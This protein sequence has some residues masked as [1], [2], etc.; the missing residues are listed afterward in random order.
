M[1]L[2]PAFT[3]WFAQ[4]GWTIRAHQAAMIAA[5]QADEHAL[6]VAATGAGK[7]LAG[8]LP[9][10]LDLARGANDGLHTLYVSPLK[11]LAA[12]IE[13]NLAAPIA[14]MGLPIRVETRSG[15]TSSD[16]KAR[17]RSRPPHILLTTPES[18]SLLLSWPDSFLLFANLKTVVIDE[19]HAF[20]TGKRGD[21]LSLA[22]ARLQTINPKL[23][24]VAL[25]ATIADPGDYCRWLAPGGDGTK[26]R[27]VAGEAGAEPD[28]R[29]LMPEGAIPWAGHSG[30]YAVHQVMAE[31]AKHRTT[32]IFCNTRGLAELL[33]QELWKANDA[34]LPIAIH[35]GSLDREARLRA[36][37]A[38]AE[39]RLRALVATSS[40]DM[41]LDW[42][43]VDCVIQ[44]GAPKGSSRLLQRIGRA[45][46]RLD[47]PSRALL[48][49][50]NR[51][52]FLE[53]QAALDAVAAGERDADAFRPGARDVLAQHVMGMAC[54]APFAE[55]DLLAEVQSAAPY[56]NVSAEEFTRIIGFVRDGG[57]ALKAYDRFRRLAPDGPGMW[58]IAHPRLITQH[59]LN[60]GII[61][62]A[63]TLDVRFK[64]GRRLGQ[65]EEYF[66]STL[67][68]GDTFAFAGLSLEVEA[69]RDLDLVV[70]ATTKPARIPSYNGA[71]IALSTRLADRVRDFL[72]HPA[73]WDRFPS[74]VRDWLRLQA[75][76]SALP[77]PGE[78]LAET[79]PHEGRHYLALYPFEGWNA[80]QS[81]GMLLT[82]R[83]ER[84][85]LQPLGFVASDYALAIWSVQ[86]VTNPAALLSP[87]ILADEFVDWVE[88]SNL[89]KRA[90]REVAVIGGLIERQHPGKRK[91][92]K[93]VT[94]STDLIFDVL[95]KFEPDHL[96]IEAAW[97]DARVR[98]TDV[99]RLGDLLDR[100]AGTMLHQRLERISPLAIPLL[101]IIGRESV[102]TAATDDSLLMEAAAQEL[103]V[104]AA[105]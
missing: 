86:P 88:G 20:A 12:D 2:P 11:A 91:T 77:R 44:M 50:G 53:A 23:R 25:S 68:V 10:L 94:F 60:A 98:L 66:A 3:Q 99:A 35:H 13:R 18:L 92:G 81:L 6:L 15:D 39:G 104:L 4:R 57:Y 16:A 102:G 67:T 96:L 85:G 72:S 19:V 28:V 73:S 89:L 41:G 93:Q 43:D 21:L 74:D 61:V 5:A 24:R 78:L 1:F 62:D 105:N 27:L 75:V 29:I 14:E 56:A 55:T 71:R 82:K 8:F 49:P 54:A 76:K 7:T 90:F 48:V 30:R 70:R 59:R 63:P 52:E 26:V 33:F 22:L 47:E 83:M 58:R 65:V 95:R 34:G 31:V 103:A 32:I 40:L 46:H 64:N 80:H 100:A 84:A 51:F 9:S 37:A 79:F 45:N 17:Q 38:M 97:A 87:D 69:M 42:G 36:E 101:V